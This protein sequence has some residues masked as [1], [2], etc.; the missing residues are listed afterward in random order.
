MAERKI[1]NGYIVQ[2]NDDGTFTT[3]GP[4]NAQPQQ[5]SVPANPI[6]VQGA[7]ADIG[8]V[9]A[10]TTGQALENRVTQETLPDVVR[11]TKAEADKAVADAAAASVAAAAATRGDQSA[12]DPA[13]ARI[14]Q[15]LQTDNV[16]GNIEAARRQIGEGWA[17]GNFFGGKAFQSIPGVGQNSADLAA[18]LSGIEGSVINDTL[19]AM[20]AMS[21]TGASGMGALSEK[22]GARLAASVAALQQSQSPDELL[23]NLA[24]VERHYRNSLAIL[25]NEDPREPAIAEKYGIVGEVDNTKSQPAISP[26]PGAGGGTPQQLTNK[27]SMENDPT[28]RGVNSTVAGMLKSGRSGDEI[29]AY[30]NSVRPGYGDSIAEI[31]KAVAWARQNPNKP[32]SDG[33]NLNLEQKW[34]PAGEVSQLLGG[35]AMTPVGSALIGAG[36]V[37]S[38]GTLDNIAGL[39]GGNAEAT[40]ALMT[41][42]SEAN[43]N[44]YAAGQILG[45]VS[46]GLGLENALGRAGMGAV[47][48]SGLSSALGGA[49]YGAGSA[50]APD[51]SRIAQ[52]LLGGTTGFI[53][54]KL[55]RGVA[56]TV[57]RTLT[58][59]QDDAVRAL[60]AA[61][62]RMTP[63]QVLGGTAARTEDR[64]AGL[65]LVGD[66]IV[67][68]RQEGITDFNRAAFNEA[69]LPIGGSIDAVGRPGATS[70]HRAV[71]DAYNSALGGVSMQ[72]DQ[73][74]MAAVNQLAP[75]VGAIP[76]VGP[77]LVEGMNA[78]ITPYIQPGGQIPGLAMQDI[79][80]ST[81]ALKRAYR[82]GASGPDPLYAT[83]IAPAVDSY[84]AILE[85][86]VRRQSP[87]TFDAFQAA[88][89]ANRNVSTL[90]D[91]VIS[92]KNQG[93]E[94]MPSQ[95]MNATTTNTKRL[96]GKRAAAEGR[97]P[98]FELAEAG[99]EVLPSK[100]PDSGTAGR[101]ALPIIASGLAGGG[102]YA[103]SEEENAP[104]SSAGA[105]IIAGLLA[106]APYSPAARA[107]LQKIML[108]E[109]PQAIE[110]IGTRMIENDRIAGLLAA[111]SSV[112][113]MTE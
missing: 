60:D 67:K 13:M 72:T 55:G 30:L 6:R 65:P 33:V 50:D 23:R 24:T 85:E 9:Q 83:H 93:G 17:A 53:G 76:R 78:S 105:A 64:L 26:T 48:A 98:F 62:V 52:A 10:R 38:L 88:N 103:A 94:F 102:T 12:A 80:Q 42:V 36:D 28:L 69:M 71:S 112:L 39:L 79:M 108:A 90:D 44:S 56:R 51:D 58:G 46:G 106:S 68:R 43:P 82:G 104:T 99:Q 109:R 110:D 87:D 45:G 86:L 2:R 61:G 20:R 25:N 49:A 7:Q 19:K 11:K 100:V 75:Q 59:V 1:I 91:A 18:T 54:D 35:A 15:S 32:I 16:L 31:D 41:G 4:A 111:P 89:R 66:Q 29:R 14:Q 8:N 74:Y 27:G 34:V 92:A 40:R 47:G 70:A 96:S 95:L 107:S 5:Q 113:Y 77:E 73:P 21:A 63:G 22:E 101:I 37:A 97:G 3:I 57:G 84:Q 81:E